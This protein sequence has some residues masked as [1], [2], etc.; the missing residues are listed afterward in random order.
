MG[1][2]SLSHW[3]TGE[4]RSR[5]ALRATRTGYLTKWA[6]VA[7]AAVPHTRL[8][9]KEI[10]SY[11]QTANRRVPSFIRRVLATKKLL[12]ELNVNI[13]LSEV[14]VFHF[15]MKFLCCHGLE[16]SSSCLWVS[17][18]STPL[19]LL[20][21]SRWQT[22]V[23]RTGMIMVE[24]VR[25][26]H[27]RVLPWWQ[28]SMGHVHKFTG[29]GE[30]EIKDS[31]QIWNLNK[32]ADSGVLYWVRKEW[33]R[34]RFEGMEIKC[35]VLDMSHSRSLL[36]VSGEMLGKQSWI[37]ER[38]QGFIFFK[39]FFWKGIYFFTY[40]KSPTYEPSS[41]KLSKMQMCPCIPALVLN[42]CTFQGTVLCKIKKLKDYFQK[43]LRVLSRSVV[44]DSLRPYDYSPPGSSVHGDS[45]GK[46]TGVGF[47]A[48]LQGI[49]PT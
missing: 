41:C 12:V 13:M 46:N 18:E 28:K 14:V 30:R 7:G 8:L 2:R 5:K 11:L 36:D 34:R 16:T 17:S 21:R 38:G 40:S 31:S 10:Q 19:R 25:S 1:M 48:L 9:C 37:P 29:I 44:S 39:L 42:Y 4:H 35:S 45:P 32:T 26:G 43:Y 49:S 24:I 6:R 15:S 3:T 27:I 22:T 33:E 47:H 23:V 20:Q